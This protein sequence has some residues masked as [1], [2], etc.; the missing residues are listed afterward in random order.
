MKEKIENERFLLL[1][2]QMPFL[3]SANLLAGL[4]LI[5]MLWDIIPRY[6]LLLWYGLMFLFWSARGLHSY[7][8]NIRLYKPGSLKTQR[9]IYY[10]F[11]LISGVFWGSA[12]ALFFT[13]E[14]TTHL[15][16]LI[17][18]Q[19]GLIAGAA[20]T[21]AYL[22]WAFPLFAFITV[23]PT[24]LSLLLENNWHH[25][26]IATTILFSMLI[27]L[28]LS[29]NVYRSI[30]HSLLIRFE[31][32]ELVEKL[33]LQAL[34]LNKQK[35]KAVKA[36]EDKSRFLASASHDLRQ[37][38]HSLTLLTDA[39]R[40]QVSTERGKS[41]LKLIRSAND[42][43]YSLLSSLL[44]ISKLD[45]GVVEPQ[46]ERIELVSLLRQ[47]VEN[48]RTVAENKGLELR[49]KV[50]HC[51]V[52]SDP[53][54][55]ASAVM[56]LLDNAIKYTAE[57]G[58]ILVAMRLYKQRVKVQ[59]WDTGIGIDEQD[60]EK[61]FDEFLQL[62]N[63]ERDGEKGLGLGLSI[64]KRILQLLG[65]SISLQSTRNK[66]S[67]FSIVMPLSILPEKTL[68]NEYHTIPNLVPDI[69]KGRT[70]LVIDDNNAV[71]SATIAALNSWGYKAITATCIEEVSDIAVSHHANKIDI[72]AADYRLRK[73]TTGIDA[74]RVFEKLSGKISMPAFL[75]TGDTD[76][77]RI[78]EASSFGLP[79]LHKPLKQGELKMVLRHFE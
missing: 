19:F 14:S 65:Y 75:I 60:K 21:L 18:F 73:N 26:W 58:C 35:E 36:N 72:I 4:G 40:P 41:I 56:N 20:I 64:S 44:D 3:S 63:P 6:Q 9:K 51:Y 50:R 7:L 12:G 13:P 52:D 53:A 67:V 62:S 71:L 11:P 66:G 29:R 74:I 39:L 22:R 47:I 48:Y 57:G 28:G 33:Q 69:R 61:I 54:L 25:F 45:A 76:P 43:L 42:S 49:F 55:L 5:A 37:P 27:M 1:Q 8:H 46:I 24:A 2:Q 77:N 38:I 70:I 79:L 30:S 15:V 10:I 34:E 17:M 31:N 32:K 78:Q 16:Y 59:I 68:F 23:I